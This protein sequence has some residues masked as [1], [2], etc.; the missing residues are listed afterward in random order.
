[1]RIHPGIKNIH[2][3]SAVSTAVQNI[4]ALFFLCLVQVYADDVQGSANLFMHSGWTNYDLRGCSW[5][6][7]AQ[8]GMER[9]LTVAPAIGL[10]ASL[11]TM[12]TDEQYGIT[13][14][15]Y[16]PEAFISATIKYNRL[17]G[18]LSLSAG[19]DISFERKSS[20]VNSSQNMPGITQSPVEDKTITGLNAAAAVSVGLKLTVISFGP[21]IS[22]RILPHGISAESG[23]SVLVAL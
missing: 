17:F 21:T 6:T 15:H 4:V 7:Y 9:S 3:R 1:M 16:I 8:I 22:V 13:S 2:C 20:I 10:G 11:F 12:I 19:P 5:T 14:Y 18:R 23:V